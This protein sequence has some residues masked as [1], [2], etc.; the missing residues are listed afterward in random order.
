MKPI[1]FNSIDKITGN[2][3]IESKNK[4]KDK[5][6][7]KFGEIFEKEIEALKNQNTSKSGNIM[8]TSQLL[9]IQNLSSD[10]IFAEKGLKLCSEINNLLD[11]MVAGLKD[12]SNIKGTIS[13]L[14]S[15]LSDLSKISEHVE[16]KDVKDIINRTIFVSNIEIEKYIRGDYS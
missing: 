13:K 6:I 2:Q 5:T 8:Q 16:D 4:Q 3:Q 1:D 12:N 14:N 15:S 11:K 10:N 9:N 7:G